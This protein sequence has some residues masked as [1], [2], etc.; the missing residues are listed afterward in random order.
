MRSVNTLVVRSQGVNSAAL[1][2]IFVRENIEAQQGI[3]NSNLGGN[4]G[5]EKKNLAPP[6]PR[7]P[8]RHPQA[9]HPPP[10]S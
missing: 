1:W 9:P 2:A 8:H 3:G 4:F 10:L 6:P 5:P 7:I